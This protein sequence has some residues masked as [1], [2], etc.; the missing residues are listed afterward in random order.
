MVRSG[1]RVDHWQALFG[2]LVSGPKSSLEL[3]RE[4]GISQPTLSRIVNA[5]R[6]ELL[7]VGRA[8]AT[9][10]ARPRPFR[11]TVTKYPVYEVDEAGGARELC[12]LTPV[13]PESFHVDAHSEGVATRFHSDLPYF[14]NDIRPAGFLGRLVPRQH[15]DLELPADVR[16]WTA[17]QCLLYLSRYGWDLPG[18]ILVGERA[19]RLYLER[20]DTQG[21]AI[22]SSRR[23]AAYADLATKI[24]SAA[25]VGSS[26]G[27]EQPKFLALRSPGPTAVLVKFSA[28][29]VDITS[30]RYADLLVAE[31]V[32]LRTLTEHGQDA[33][34]SEL[35]EGRSRLFLEVERFDR[36]RRGGRRGVL[37]LF[38]LDAEFV[39]KLRSWSESA[40]LLAE[41]RH[42]PSDLVPQVRFREWFG[43]LIGN[44]DMHPGNLSFFARGARVTGLAPAYDMLPMR[45]APHQASMPSD[46][47]APPVPEPAVAGQWDAICEAAEGFWHAV[48]H[49]EL[50]SKPFRKIATANALGVSRAKRLGARLG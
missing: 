33:A 7:V 48:S 25:P 14:L 50:A 47:L 28:E 13:L 29:I 46:P 31:H 18:A 44:T 4:L 36:T 40:T 37:S 39:G 16:S 11:G 9:R 20:S 38:S 17:D 10:Y 19:L 23:A 41:Q 8:R 27:G 15:P 49:H 6:G 3:T 24:L 12:R 26:A 35:V 22:T 1:G 30:R 42:V 34:V 2:T 21:R 45:Y 5:H 43:H 32:A